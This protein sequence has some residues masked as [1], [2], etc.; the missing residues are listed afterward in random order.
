MREKAAANLKKNVAST[1]PNCNIKKDTA[2]A[3]LFKPS[4]TEP[5]PKTFTEATGSAKKKR[6]PSKPE[7]LSPMSTYEI[8]DREDID[9]DEDSDYEDQPRKKIPEWAKKGNLYPAL[10]RQFA[11]ETTRLD[12]DTIFHAIHSCDLEA[13]FGDKKQ[14]KYK[15]RTSSGNWTKDRVTAAEKLTYKRTMGYGVA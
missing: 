4:P 7:I 8:S 3:E 13:I 9:S 5:T 10:E 1:V 11:P 15:Q 14:L 2:K 12:P 6:G